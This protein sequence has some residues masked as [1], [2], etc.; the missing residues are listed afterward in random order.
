MNRCTVHLESYGATISVSRQKHLHANGKVRRRHERNPSKADDLEI[1]PL[2]IIQSL[3]T[4]QNLIDE[5]YHFRKNY[6]SRGA[7][8]RSSAFLI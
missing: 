5:M 1:K 7:I 6:I 2:P 8:T 3:S 4:S